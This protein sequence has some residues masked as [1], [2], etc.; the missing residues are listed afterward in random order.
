MHSR[1]LQQ[2]AFVT[3]MALALPALAQKPEPETHTGKV[4]SIQMKGRIATIKIETDAGDTFS[5]IVTPKVAFTVTAK[6]EADLLK[7]LGKEPVMISAERTVWNEATKVY[8]A[9]TL[10]VYHKIKV[11]N[12]R[13][14]M[15]GGV[16]FCAPLVTGTDKEVIL[17]GGINKV[18][19]EGATFALNV[20]SNDA[21]LVTEGAQAELEGIKKGEKFLASRLAITLDKELT[22]EDVSMK[23]GSK[24]KT[25]SKPA[26]KADDKPADKATD[27]PADKATD[28]TDGKP[29]AATDPFKDTKDLKDD[30]AKKGGL[31]ATDPFK[32]GVKGD[33]TPKGPLPANDP[34]KDAGKGDKPK[35]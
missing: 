25:T 23:K 35:S 3:V 2:I 30:K 22:A 17:G 6:A 21:T 33:K 28:K 34:F 8:V 12:G 29:L 27:K 1:F 11:K 10:T 18:V 14:E 32:G 31:T 20:V 13:T 5:V 26:E 7:K 9:G 19:P 15:N 16:D 4:S 24:A